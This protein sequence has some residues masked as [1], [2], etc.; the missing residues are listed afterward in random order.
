MEEEEEEGGEEGEGLLY[1]RLLG[2]SVDQ[3]EGLP[4]ERGEGEAS[5]GGCLREGWSCKL[6]LPTQQRY[7]L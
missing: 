5:M 2:R 4:V 1:L 3:R 7:H 6:L